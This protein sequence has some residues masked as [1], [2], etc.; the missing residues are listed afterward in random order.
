MANCVGISKCVINAIPFDDIILPKVIKEQEDFPRTD[1]SSNI[2][3][4][5]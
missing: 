4:S 5:Y 1:S 2:I 3:D